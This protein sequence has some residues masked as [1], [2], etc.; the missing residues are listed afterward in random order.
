MLWSSRGEETDDVSGDR[1]QQGMQIF[2]KGMTGRTITLTVASDVS[3]EAIKERIW[4]REKVPISQ[5]RLRYGGKQ[6]EDGKGLDDYHIRE[7]STLHL[8]TRLRGGGPEPNYGRANSSGKSLGDDKKSVEQGAVK[9]LRSERQRRLVAGADI[10]HVLGK[11]RAERDI[12]LL[13]LKKA[14]TAL[15]LLQ[16]ERARE[17]AERAEEE[18]VLARREEDVRVHLNEALRMQERM[19]RMLR[20]E[21][22]EHDR[23]LRQKLQEESYAKRVVQSR[24]EKAEAEIAQFSEAHCAEELAVLRAAEKHWRTVWYQVGSE[25]AAEKHKSASLKVEFDARLK[26]WQTFHDVEMAH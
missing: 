16:A 2:I 9:E 20:Q 10:R 18:R 3:I 25:L 5:Q 15:K 13:R 14:Q 12:A 7:E 1:S 17:E 24:L 22:D 19:E 11:E 8:M 21:S 4:R 26:K 23:G 6:L